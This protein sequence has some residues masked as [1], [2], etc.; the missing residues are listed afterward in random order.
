MGGSA[1]EKGLAVTYRYS[2]GYSRDLSDTLLVQSAHVPIPRISPSRS[3][4]TTVR[5]LQRVLC[6]RHP[7]ISVT[8]IRH[9]LCLSRVQLS[10]ELGPSLWHRAAS[11]ATSPPPPRQQTIDPAHCRSLSEMSTILCSVPT[12]SALP[13][14]HVPTWRS[15]TII[16]SRIEGP[17]GRER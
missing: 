15:Y 17:T 11:I 2:T 1:V 4:N 7:H 8:L 12:S 16:T 5:V 14:L 10:D 6:L 3:R 9:D 13:P